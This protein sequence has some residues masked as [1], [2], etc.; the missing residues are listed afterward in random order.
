MRV[1][2]AIGIR[3][4]AEL[5]RR[6][7][8]R[9]CADAEWHLLHVIDVGPRDDLE[10]FGPPHRPPRP[11]PP[12]ESELDRAEDVSGEDALKEALDAL[13]ALGLQAETRLERGRPNQVIVE[14]AQRVN[15]DLIAIQAQERAAHPRQGPVPVGHTARSILDHAPCDVLLLRSG[16]GK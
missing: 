5:V 9:I 2:C 4:G 7:V 10:R 6:T 14:V 16:N 3:G 11:R 8:A 1:L 15:A 12:H 13:Q